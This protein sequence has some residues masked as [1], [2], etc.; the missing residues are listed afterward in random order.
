MLHPRFK[1]PTSLQFFLSPSFLPPSNKFAN[2][3]QQP[4]RYRPTGKAFVGALEKLK[5]TGNAGLTHQK[6][7]RVE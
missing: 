3:T 5:S 4:A 2:S 1:L 6:W 7:V